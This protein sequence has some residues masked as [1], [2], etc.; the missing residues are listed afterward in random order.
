MITHWL[1]PGGEG[2]EIVYALRNNSTLSN[3]ILNNIGEEG[4]IKRKVY[5]RRLPENPSKDYY[6]IIRETTPS[7]AVL[8]E[9]GF[10]DNPNDL[11]RLQNNLDDYAEGVVKALANYMNVPY[12]KPGSGPSTG[13][14]GYYTV[15]RGD[16][17]W[18]I[19]NQFGLTVDELKRLNNL[20][21]NEIINKIP[22]IYSIESEIKNYLCFLKNIKNSSFFLY[23]LKILFEK[24]SIF[25]SDFNFN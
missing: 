15:V 11:R 6:Y 24:V 21:T 4:Q 23:K 3:M 20:T 19:A 16:T 10:I 12:T 14:E 18:S 5:Q 13:E 1:S 2:A 25:S 17:L 8:I 7:E 9:Y 22:F